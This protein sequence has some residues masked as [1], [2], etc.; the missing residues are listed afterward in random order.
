MPRPRHQLLFATGATSQPRDAR[1]G[2]E[3]DVHAD[4][5][6]HPACSCRSL[7]PPGSGRKER[8]RQKATASQ[9]PL[10]RILARTGREQV[11]R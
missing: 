7:E 3:G 4:R 8:S 2:L 11:T 9:Q 10:A 1:K 6:G 5:G